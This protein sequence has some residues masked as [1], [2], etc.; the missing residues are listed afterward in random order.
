MTDVAK[1]F[2]VFFLAQSDKT[3]ELQKDLS[4]CTL[5]VNPFTDKHNKKA[6]KK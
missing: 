5:I 1:L 6:K 3:F 2:Y 4:K